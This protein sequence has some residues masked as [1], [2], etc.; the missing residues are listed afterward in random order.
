MQFIHKQQD[1][2]VCFI[3]QESMLLYR[4]PEECVVRT[5]QII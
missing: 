1:K 4:F 5:N 3:T 2:M